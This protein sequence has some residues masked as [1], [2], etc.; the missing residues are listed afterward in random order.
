MLIFLQVVRGVVESLKII[1]R[2][3]SL[4]VAEYAF[5]YAKANGRE[6]VSAIHKANIM[7]KTDGLFL[8]VCDLL[9]FLLF[10][11]GLHFLLF[12]REVMFCSHLFCL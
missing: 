1:T 7:R 8:K 11:H 10:N 9:L 12:C 3:A 5:H 6:R 4:R 2:Q